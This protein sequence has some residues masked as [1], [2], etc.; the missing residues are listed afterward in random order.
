[1]LR[2]ASDFKTNYIF[3]ILGSRLN[4]CEVFSEIDIL[5]LALVPNVR[6]SLI[7]CFVFDLIPYF[8]TVRRGKYVY[9][10]EVFTGKMNVI[11]L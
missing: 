6:T 5:R 10:F 11:Q 1:M 2:A 3:G 4:Y 7:A 9:Q 8:R